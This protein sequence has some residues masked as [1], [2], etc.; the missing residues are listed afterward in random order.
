MTATETRPSALAEFAPPRRAR[1]LD[2]RRLARLGATAA[3]VQMFV[4]LTAMP[5]RLDERPVIESL[6]SLGYLFIGVIPVIAGNR[7]GRQ[8]KL[9][10][11]PIHRAG[12]Y[13]L[14][15]G[16]LAGTLAGAGLSLL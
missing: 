5:V 15:G 9:E 13:E 11:V 7:I 8:V 2:W 1:D 10:G 4:S 6:L 12:R 14:L 16:T 3:F